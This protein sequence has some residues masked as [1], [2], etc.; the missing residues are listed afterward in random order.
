MQGSITFLVLSIRI[1][2]Y[3][4]ICIHEKHGLMLQKQ[5]ID[6]SKTEYIYTYNGLVSFR[7]HSS[8]LGSYRTFFLKGYEI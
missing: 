3:P 6:L 4:N 1:I 2:S 5:T 8:P 7:Q